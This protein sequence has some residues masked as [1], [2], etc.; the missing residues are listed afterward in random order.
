M[1]MRDQKLPPNTEV[2]GYTLSDRGIDFYFRY[3][4]QKDAP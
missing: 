1:L 3:L 4:R 2:I